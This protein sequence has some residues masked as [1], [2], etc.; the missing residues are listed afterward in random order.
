MQDEKS[1]AVSVS[2]IRIFRWHVLRYLRRHPLLA[3]LNILSVALGVA[4]YLATQIANHSANRAFAATVDLVAG[5]AELEI[6]APTAR[7]PETLFPTVAATHGI[8]A[9]TPIVRG[10]VTL[11]DFP[12][13]YLAVLGIDIFTNEPFRTFDPTGFDAAELDIQQ[14]LGPPGSIA[15]AEEFVARHHL[16]AGDKIRARVNVV[17]RDLRVGFI[18]RSKGAPMLD[19]HFAAMDLGWAQELFA[20]G[21]ELSAIQLRLANPRDRPKV[22]AELRKILPADA[23]VTAPAQRTEEVDKMLGGF[24]LNLSAMSLVSLVVGMFLIYNTVSASVAR[25]RHEIGILRSLGVTRNEVRALFLGE[26][27]SLGSIGVLL[28]LVGGTLLARLLA[29]AVAETISSLYVLVQVKQVALEPLSFALAGIIG[30]G[31]VIVS[32]WLPAH[33]AANMDPVRA[34]HGS[35][36]STNAS[37]PSASFWWGGIFSLM[38]AV[39]F[40]F[41]ALS[42]GPPWLSFAAAFFVLTSFSLF[43]PP[44]AFQFSAK[45]G[46]FFRQLRRGRRKAA[47]EAEL[48][49]AN[50]SRAL[51][52]NSVTIA[53]LAAAVAMTVGVSVMVFSFR[54]TVETWINDTLIAD[55][56]IAPASN[57]IVGPSSFIPPAAVHF[58]ETHPAVETIDTFRDAELPM[59]AETIAVAVVRGNERRQFQFV[60]G[61]SATIMRRFH[62]E[63]CVIVSEAFGRRRNVRDGDSLELTTPEGPR[64]FAIAGVF[65]DYTRDQGVVYLSE[66]NFVRYWRDDRVNSVA[67]YLKKNTPAETLIDPFRKEFSRS[68]EFLVY[69]N[70]SLRTRIF[71]I[72]DQTF[73]VTYVLLTIAIIVAITGIFL[74]LTILIT[75]RSREL[76]VFRAIGGSAGQVRKLLLWETAMIGVLAALVGMASG[77]CLSLVLTGVINRAFF[78]WTIRLAFPWST[79]AV[80][81]LWIVAAALVAGLVP[82]WRAGRMVLTQ[83]LRNE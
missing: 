19:A 9:A 28:G 48:A 47:V 79:L 76:A 10:L 3:L 50:L 1:S 64:K 33:A 13:E 57:E 31:S 37:T 15:L 68:G 36:S 74:S 4:V 61:N 63:A 11:P 34:L 45:A 30:L 81:P 7:L 18:L 6:T 56:F 44:L 62:D 67:V 51:M 77:L 27:I 2:Y 26:A 8:S 42:T 40:S 59:G 17:D 75:E 52:R 53:T 12:G 49:A 54:E 32:A 82:A 39:A 46:G 66:Q 58:L 35:D 71:E 29:G 65:Y 16:K 21:G 78:G 41:L 55:L 22:V 72:F 60:R 38:L 14:W 43:V 80:T 83:S 20:R 5:K 69:S 23:S 73:A 25:R 24:E 70:Q